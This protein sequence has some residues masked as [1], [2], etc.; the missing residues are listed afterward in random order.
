MDPSWNLRSRLLAVRQFNPTAYML[1]HKRLSA[2][3]HAYITKVFSEFGISERM[4]VC[5][6]TDA[7][8]VLHRLADELLPSM[9]E[10]SIPHMLSCAL[11]EV[12]PWLWGVQGGV[13]TRTPHGATSCW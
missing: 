3:L 8:S 11:V 6:T 12:I 7:G 4:L 9:W 2:L 13:D 1:E 5:S 10:W